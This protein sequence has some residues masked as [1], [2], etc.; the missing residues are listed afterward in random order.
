MCVAFPFPS[1]YYSSADNTLRSDS[2]LVLILKLIHQKWKRFNIHNSSPPPSCVFFSPLCGIIERSV[3]NTLQWY[4]KYPEKNTWS[5]MSREFGMI[6][7][8]GIPYN[9]NTTEKSHYS[10]KPPTLSG[11]SSQFEWWK[12]KMYT[13]IM[14]LMISYRVSLK[15]TLN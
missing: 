15:M 2:K 10:Y 13:Y 1:K 11:D 3:Q 4:K 8:R 9:Y 6:G 14:V 5:F 7:I 12:S